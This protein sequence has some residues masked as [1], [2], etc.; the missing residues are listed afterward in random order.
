[1]IAHSPIRGRELAALTRS[2]D[3]ELGGVAARLRFGRVTRR[4]EPRRD[5]Q[6]ALFA[7]VARGAEATGHTDPT[8]ALAVAETDELVDATNSLTAV[9]AA[10]DS[11]R[12]EHRDQ[13]RDGVTANTATSTNS[14]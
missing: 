1:M 9:L 12:G 6:R 13:L 8:C 7:A 5:R 14:R 11:P 4:L 3:V 10:T 2:V